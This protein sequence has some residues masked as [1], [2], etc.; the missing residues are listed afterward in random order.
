MT[1]RLTEIAFFF[2]SQSNLI[3]YLLKDTFWGEY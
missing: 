1:I 2:H 3:L